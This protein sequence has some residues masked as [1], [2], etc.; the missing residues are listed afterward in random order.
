MVAMSLAMDGLSG[1]GTTAGPGEAGVIAIFMYYLGRIDAR[2][3]G[4]DYVAEVSRLV[5][6]PNYVPR[7]FRADLQ[8]CSGEA[9]R[10]GAALKE[11][12]EA[13]QRRAPIAGTKP[14]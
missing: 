2:L 11:M 4:I 6:S 3:P 8:R 10:R 5:E 14:G 1:E 7:K 9:Q 13:L 12:G